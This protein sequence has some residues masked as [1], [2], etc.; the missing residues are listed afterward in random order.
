MTIELGFWA[1]VA[2]GAVLTLVLATV[3]LL[4]AAGISV[5]RKRRP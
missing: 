3:A 5:A 2:A 4:I 1:G